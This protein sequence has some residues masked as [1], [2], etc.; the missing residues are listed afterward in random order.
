MEAEIRTF[1]VEF[2]PGVFVVDAASDVIFEV[3]F[4]DFQTNREIWGDTFRGK[5]N[6]SS[7]IAVT[8]DMFEK[9]INAAYAE[10]MKSLYTT[11]SDEKI[12]GV[13]KQ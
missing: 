3:R 5:G 13:L 12:K 1:W 9:S 2:M 11:I 10:A 6:V 4:I 7:G 8:K